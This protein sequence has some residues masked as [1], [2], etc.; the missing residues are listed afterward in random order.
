MSTR[1]AFAYQQGVS[2]IELITFIVII[3]VALA[4]ILLVMSV[5]T[6][7]SADPLIHKQALAIAE[8]ML[9]EV[10]LMPFTYCDPDDAS[11]VTA[12]SATVGGTGCNAT[13]E[14]PGPETIA[15]AVETR[16]G[17]AGVNTQFDNV[18]D[19]A[20]FGMAAGAILDITGAPSGTIGYTVAPIAVTPVALL[21]IPATDANGAAQVLQ[22]TVSVDHWACEMH[23][24]VTLDGYRTR[25]APNSVP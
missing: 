15:G 13:K 3:S 5:T 20:G 19:Y 21:G 17:A 4:G 24:C 14:A 8:A 12:T 18:N 11:A 6:R 25:Y 22:I 7:N 1:R 23:P 10:E 2:L 16:Y 9:E